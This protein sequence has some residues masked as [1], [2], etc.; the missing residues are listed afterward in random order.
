MLMTGARYLASLNDGRQVYIEGER[1]TNLANHPALAI[2]V[3][4]TVRCYDHYYTSDPDAVNPYLAT[5][6]TADELRARPEMAT[7]FLTSV[8]FSSIMALLTAGDRIAETRPQGREAI[9]NYVD[10]MRKNDLRITECITDPKGD[11]SLPPLKQSDPDAYLRVVDRRKDGVVIRGA[12]LH[13][14]LAA[15]G[16][17]LMVIPTKS[18]KEGEQDYA[19]ACGVPANADGVKIVV[20]GDP[21]RTDLRDWPVAATDYVPQCFVLFDDVFVPNDRVFLDGETQHAASFAHALGLWL[22]ATTLIGSASTADTLVGLAQLIAEANGLERVS[23]IRDKI[24]DMMM[25]ATLIRA[26][27]EAALAT[28]TRQDDGSILPNELYANAGKYLGAAETGLMIRHLLDIAGGSALTAPS[29]RDLES[30][31]TGEL[32]RKYMGTKPE[33]DGLYRTRLFHAIR[34]IAVSAHGGRLTIGRLQ[35][36]GG[37]YAQK[38]AA[39]GRYDMNRAKKLALQLMDT[40]DDGRSERTE[41]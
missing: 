34:D 7:D 22:R 3:A 16:H 26:A 5:P 14:S 30:P 20:V 6:Q 28:G 11:R 8:T 36:A 4:E 2:P 24:R 23:H 37:L 19:I 17:E 18:M 39:R 33:I 27:V 32:L 13:V 38:I 25:H 41:G 9:R 15:V 31:D 35:G 40:A 1:V 21:P 29:N 10:Y 12:K